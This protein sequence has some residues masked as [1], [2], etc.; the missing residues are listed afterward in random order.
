MP[1]LASL[2]LRPIQIPQEATLFLLGGR[3][4]AATGRELRR[5]L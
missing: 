5:S 2:V 3:R 4:P 1:K